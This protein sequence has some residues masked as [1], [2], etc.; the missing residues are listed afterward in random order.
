MEK[1][2]K[3]FCFPELWAIGFSI[4]TF[5][6]AYAL[7]RLL[8]FVMHGLVKKE[9]MGTKLVKRL[10]L[11]VLWLFIEIAAL[12]SLHALTSPENRQ[13]S[14]EHAVNVLMIG[15]IGWFFV[16]VTTAFYHH[17]LSKNRGDERGNLAHRSV[18]TQALFLYR[19]LIFAIIALTAAA[20]LMTFPYIK[21]IGVGILG[22]AGIAGIALGI[23]ARPILLNLMAGFQIAATKTIKIGDTLL[24]EGESAR[25]ETIHLTH[26]VM[27]TWDLRRIIL[28]ISYFIDKPFQNWDATN[29]E[30]L[31]SIFLYCDYTLPLDPLRAKVKEL[32]CATPLWNKKEWNVHV[33]N[34]TTQCLEIRVS[35]SVDHSGS[36]FDL[37]AYLREK[38]IDFLQKEY[39]EA[40]PCVRNYQLPLQ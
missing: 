18:L 28:P 2:F 32:L 40:L 1:F 21:N 9:G 5:M 34:C 11:P 19:L 37:R 29:P 24:V 3:C 23:A 7:Y 12:I 16:S 15:T 10:S 25:V 31:A 30:L 20:I 38:L 13:P 22:S 14:L 33:T 4:A 17:F 8:L 36:T 6:L 35:A 39:P 26:I 27:R